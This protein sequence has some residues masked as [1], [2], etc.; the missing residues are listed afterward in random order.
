MDGAIADGQGPPYPLVTTT[1]EDVIG[2]LTTNLGTYSREGGK[3]RKA[4]LATSRALTPRR[5]NL[6][7][8][9]KAS[10]SP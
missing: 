9:P 5:M 3:R 8:T 7:N 6:Y 1:S 2:N 10:V 4:V